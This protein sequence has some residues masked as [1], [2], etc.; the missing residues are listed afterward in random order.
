MKMVI[1]LFPREHLSEFLIFVDEGLFWVQLYLC[2]LLPHQLMDTLEEVYMQEWEVWHFIQYD[3]FTCYLLKISLTR[4]MTLK[5]WKILQ[6]S[7]FWEWYLNSVNV[8]LC[9]FFITG[10][11]WIKQMM[12]GAFMLPVAV[13]GT[14]FFINF[15]AIYYHASR[16]IPFG[17]MVNFSFTFI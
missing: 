3:I 11:V 2:M 15:I 16:A 4:W 1:Y 5:H 8:F 12:V 14:A 6:Y 7:C 9:F 10:K 17:T 13:C